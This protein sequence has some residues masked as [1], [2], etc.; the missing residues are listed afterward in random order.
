MAS[1]KDLNEEP[2]FKANDFHVN[3]DKIVYNYSIIAKKM[4]HVLDT[5]IT[6]NK[7]NTAIGKLK[8][9]KSASNDSIYN[10]MI[11]SASE[12]LSPSLCKLFNLILQSDKGYFPP[13]NGQ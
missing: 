2:K 7:V 4:V 11:K 9:N 12:I 5:M 8:S 13:K 10:E 6:A 1:F 3:I